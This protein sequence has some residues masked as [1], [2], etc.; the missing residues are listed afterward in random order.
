MNISTG[1]L[2][3]ALNPERARR[4]ISGMVKLIKLS[5]VDFDTIVFR[6]MSGALIAPTVAHRLK[7]CITIS[8]KEND[9]SHNGGGII[10]G[11]VDIQKYI[12]LDDFIS[13]GNT[14]KAILLAFQ[15][16]CIFRE[17]LVKP[18][19]VGVFLYRS[20]SSSPFVI[21]E[22]EDGNFPNKIS[23]PIFSHCLNYQKLTSSFYGL[24]AT[25]AQMA[26][27]AESMMK[28]KA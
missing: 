11:N 24:P 7:K 20:S 16:S 18:K 13:T 10:E 5:G 2:D 27:R 14:I 8:R 21:E 23:I 12:I 25:P 9:S 3:D 6:G 26:K 17:K 28:E 19:C 15:R 22:G 4:T 1:Y